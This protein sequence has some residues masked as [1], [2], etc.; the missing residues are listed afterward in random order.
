MDRTRPEEEQSGLKNNLLDWEERRLDLLIKKVANAQA[1]GRIYKID[2][3]SCMI[4]EI[5]GTKALDIPEELLM[6]ATPESL[7]KNKTAAE[8]CRGTINAV[9]TTGNPISISIPI[10]INNKTILRFVHFKRASRETDSNTVI[11][12][13]NDNNTT[14]TTGDLY[15]KSANRFI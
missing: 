10:T 7:I 3:T 6:N 4:V 14:W 8:Y 9:H 5:L 1:N 13:T 15:A 12:Y 2:V 11:A